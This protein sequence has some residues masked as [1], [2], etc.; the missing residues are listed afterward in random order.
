MKFKVNTV[1]RN[2]PGDNGEWSQAL[3]SVVNGPKLA[4][5]VCFRGSEEVFNLLSE[6]MELAAAQKKAVTVTGEFA[7][8]SSK[9]I[10]GVR[11]ESYTT[12]EGKAVTQTA[13]YL[14]FG[15]NPQFAFE[16]LGDGT[17]NLA[18]LIAQH[19]AN[20]DNAQGPEPESF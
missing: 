14:R 18:A 1:I 12:K 16:A 20:S 8:A 15:D 19:K 5:K 17:G 7:E 3:C 11:E 4:D 9:G 2:I 13:I 10:T 6:A